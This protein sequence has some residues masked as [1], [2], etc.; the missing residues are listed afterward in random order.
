MAVLTCDEDATGA[1]VPRTVAPSIN[2]MAPMA[3]M[4]P[5]PPLTSAVSV[6][7]LFRLLFRLELLKVV[8]VAIGF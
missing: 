6:T 8:V 3:E 7:A 4:G 2:E 1:T 5:F